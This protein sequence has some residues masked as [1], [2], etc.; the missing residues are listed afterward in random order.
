MMRARRINL[1]KGLDPRALEGQPASLSTRL[2]EILGRQP[3]QI[4]RLQ[5]RPIAIDDG[6]PGRVPVLA[7]HDHML[8]EES[9]ELETEP[10]R[11][12]FRGRVEIVALPFDP[13]IAA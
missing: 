2:V 8:P 13:P 4:S 3:G 10:L 5:T 11:R 6:E 1:R 12:A 7:L 9:F